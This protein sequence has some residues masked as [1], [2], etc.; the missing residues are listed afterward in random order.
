MSP[1]LSQVDATRCG[2]LPNKFYPLWIV[3]GISPSLCLS[4][5]IITQLSILFLDK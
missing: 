5:I 1:T 2:S 3:A 4:W